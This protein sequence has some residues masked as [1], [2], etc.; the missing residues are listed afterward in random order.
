M[1][2]LGPTTLCKTK[3]T[4]DVEKIIYISSRERYCLFTVQDI[5]FLL[6]F[7]VSEHLASAHTVHE[8][9]KIKY[10]RKK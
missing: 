6:S 8:C 2:H 10:S 3:G 9:N 5:V 1:T 4:N 7:E